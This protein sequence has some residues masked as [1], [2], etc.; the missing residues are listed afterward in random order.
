MFFEI[1]RLTS[2][3]HLR[4]RRPYGYAAAIAVLRQTLNKPL[5]KP[6]SKIIKT[7]IKI[8]DKKMNYIFK[9]YILIYE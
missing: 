3:L 5:D 4:C 8:S 1:Q 7:L 9:K 6:I 2:L